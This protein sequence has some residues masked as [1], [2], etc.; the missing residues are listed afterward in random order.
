MKMTVHV[1]GA[2]PQYI[3]MNSEQTILDALQGAGITI[4]APCGGKG[5]C[6]RCSVLVKDSAGM[7]H[8]LACQTRITED[9]EV[10]FEGT[11]S[12]MVEGVN[13]AHTGHGPEDYVGPYGVGIDVGTTTIVFHL[14][15]IGAGRIIATSG[16]VNPQVIYGGDVLSRIQN[17][18]TPEGFDNICSLLRTC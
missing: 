7:A 10:F 13:D 18:Q 3:T 12:I 2:E 1:V 11:G 8:K 4:Y 9:S 14:V 17:S 6:H 5:R 16:T 15:D